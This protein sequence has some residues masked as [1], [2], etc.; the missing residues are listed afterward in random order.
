MKGEESQWRT[1]A[2]RHRGAPMIDRVVVPVDFTPE[3]DRAISVASALASRAGATVDLLHLGESVNRSYFV[4]QL[5]DEAARLGGATWRFVELTGPIGSALHAELQRGENELW[6]VGSHARGAIGELLVGSLS[7]D[8]VRQAHA[9]VVLVGPHA[10]PEARGG[11]L[12]VALDGT[13]ESEA[14]LPTATD[15]AGTL[16]MSLRLLQVGRPARLP[17]DVIE[18]AYLASVAAGVSSIPSRA[19]DYDTLHGDHPAHDLADY[20]G[21]HP[22]IG[23][24]AMVTRGLRG[25]DRLRHGSTAFE[26]AHRAVVPVMI[27]RV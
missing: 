27:L 8:L 19:A 25:G 9:P 1:V 24:V 3:S 12:A 23:M 5:A 7:E 11:V 16:G 13:V 18:T 14:V 26:V 21:S 4:T 2:R 17:T 15:L 20:L 6:C 10:S 22:D